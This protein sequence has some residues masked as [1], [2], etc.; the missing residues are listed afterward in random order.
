MK[1]LKPITATIQGTTHLESNIDNQDVVASYV[2]NGISVV[3]IADGAGTMQ[4]PLEGASVVATSVCKYIV[5]NFAKM[6][7][8]EEVL[9]VKKDLVDFLITKLEKKAKKYNCDIEEFASTLA[10]VCVKENEQCIIGHIGDGCVCGKTDDGWSVISFEEK[11]GP[12]NETQFITTPNVYAAMRMYK[13][14]MEDYEA[15]CLMSD[16]CMSAF[17]QEDLEITSGI[18]IMNS[19]VE[20][21]PEEVAVESIVNTLDTQVREI[22]NDDSSICFLSK[23]DYPCE[24]DFLTE[25]VKQQI[26]EKHYSHIYNVITAVEDASKII[27]VLKTTNANAQYISK[28]SKVKISSCQKLTDI[29]LKSNL[30]KIED[31]LF[32]LVL[33]EVEVDE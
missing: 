6:F 31:D 23:V 5:A 19:W 15:F 30:I 33:C 20:E 22:T 7:S 24:F 13:G 29:L 16:G 17:V 32:S 9:D 14:S 26:F 28:K 1:F 3:V 27:E 8:N 2:K 21:Y 12:V 18:D 10:F 4:H 25:E 11:N